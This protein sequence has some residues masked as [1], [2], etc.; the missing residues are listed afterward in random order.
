M[1][2]QLIL[3]VII[4]I[5]IL[6]FAFEQILDY[7]NFTKFSA[8]QPEEAENIYDN[9]KYLNQYNYQRTNYKFGLFEGTFG[10]ILSISMLL[11]YGF[12]FVDSLARELVIDER[13]VI[14]V[15]FGLLFF[16]FDI[17]SLPF[18]IYD[19]FII[20]AKF[21][22][23]KTTVT[24]FILDKL[25]EW[26]LSVVIGVP[27]ILAVFWFY[28]QTGSMFWI[29]TFLLFVGIMVFFL[30][31][32][33]NLIVPLFNKQKPL[34]EGELKSA[35]NEFA[36]K[37]SF[38]LKDIYVIDGSKRSS[39]ANAYFTG[40]GRKKRIVLYDT[41]IKDL[42]VNEIVAVLSHE[43]GH[44]KKK[45]VISGTILSIIQTGLMLYILS[46][47]LDNPLLSQALGVSKPSFQISI[48]AFGILYSPV[49]MILGIANTII[50]RKNEYAADKYAADY[51]QAEHL[52]SALKKLTVNNLS[53]LTPHPVYVFFNYSHPT[54]LQR[55]KAL[56]QNSNYH[57]LL[58]KSENNNNHQCK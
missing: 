16:S 19:T 9:E 18:N 41:L 53:N 38:S 33:S 46:F 14:L 29:Y 24:T 8:I 37:V 13:L 23:N 45:H 28:R 35:I 15:F 50:S 7:L 47:F 3:I 31:F 52:I 27:V 39:K 1:T 32:Y 55:I 22:F 20:E 4:G 17:I 51:G 58:N 11:F 36:K 49:S 6:G 34:E 56:K 30:L 10:F 26:L 2:P 54:V 44:N 5:V 57:P 40:L 12:A 21:G 43:I 48:I 25:K 42:S